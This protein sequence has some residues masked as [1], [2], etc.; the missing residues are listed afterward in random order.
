M[1]IRVRVLICLA[2]F[3]VSS[4]AA[5][6]PPVPPR[7]PANANAQP[8]DR[9]VPVQPPADSAAGAAANSNRPGLVENDA[10][11]DP[12]SN[13]KQV[14]TGPQGYG[15][16]FEIW[17]KRSVGGDSKLVGRLVVTGTTVATGMEPSHEHFFW[18]DGSYAWNRSGPLF[19]KQVSTDVRQETPP[20][21]TRASNV[22]KNDVGCNAAA[23]ATPT[24]GQWKVITGGTNPA[25]LILSP[26]A[27]FGYWRSST[28]CASIAPG[29]DGWIDLVPVTETFTAK[30]WGTPPR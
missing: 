7:P 29:A 2:L 15:L 19:L 24:T 27:L 23:K 3:G 9:P 28:R 4:A 13:V 14:S 10:V 8:P 30:S 26:N 1:S 22:Y 25:T 11:D 21:Q 17:S 20:P 12:P 16:G 18:F 6:T 5:I